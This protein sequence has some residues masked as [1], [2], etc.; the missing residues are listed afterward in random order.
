[1]TPNSPA[2]DPPNGQ[3]PQPPAPPGHTPPRPPPAKATWMEKAAAVVYCIFCL[4]IGLFLLVYPWL[5]SWEKN[6]L[7]NLHPALS[8]FLTTV[9]FRGA[10]SGLGLLNLFAAIGEIIGLRRYSSR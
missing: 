6:Y 10:V 3:P 8:G 2:P 9:Q 5:P 4:E 1:M 7:I